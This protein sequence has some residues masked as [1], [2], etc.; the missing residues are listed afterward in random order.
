M[1]IDPQRLRQMLHLAQ[2]LERDKRFVITAEAKQGFKELEN[3]L[4]DYEVEGSL[5]A[6]ARVHDVLTDLHHYLFYDNH[7]VL[8]SKPEVER[9]FSNLA[10]GAGYDDNP[11]V[12]DA[13]KKDAM[14]K[15]FEDRVVKPLAELRESVTN[16]P[17]WAEISSMFDSARRVFIRSEHARK[18][19]SMS[20]WDEKKGS[21]AFSSTASLSDAEGRRLVRAVRQDD[22]SLE[23]V[24]MPPYLSRKEN[25]GYRNLVPFLENNGVAALHIQF[26]SASAATPPGPAS[27]SLRT[28]LKQ[29]FPS[30]VV[31]SHVKEGQSL[32]LVTLPGRFTSPFSTS[33]EKVPNMRRVEIV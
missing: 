7:D 24:P 3:A 4:S 28:V 16:T 14:Y 30:L 27:S 18:L 29:G 33:R 31:D 23:L 12:G 5:L 2:E 11:A 6:L 26:K 8:E 10:H 21:K 13:L 32:W 20:D 19:F 22:G 17:R 1:H 25:M 15:D 9:D